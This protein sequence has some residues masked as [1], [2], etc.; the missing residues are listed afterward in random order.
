[1]EGQRVFAACYHRGIDIDHI[2]AED[3]ELK[4]VLVL[5]NSTICNN[6]KND[7]FFTPNFL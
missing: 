5:G 1:M 2:E 4:H 3:M 7:Y 6:D